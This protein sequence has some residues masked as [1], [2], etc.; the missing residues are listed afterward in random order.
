MQH[1]RRLQ[2]SCISS[3]RVSGHD[4]KYN[5]NKSKNTHKQ[6]LYLKVRLKFSSFFCLYLST[7]AFLTIL[8]FF[9]IYTS[10]TFGT[11][12]YHLL[13]GFPP[14]KQ[15]RHW[16]PK[17]CKSKYLMSKDSRTWYEV[18]TIPA[19]AEFGPACYLSNF[20]KP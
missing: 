18:K 3:F 10:K 1:H 8:Y 11:K 13:S 15:G 7:K 9:N 4:H 14:K 2:P 20:D 5:W 6:L 19:S 17:F 12:N 16:I